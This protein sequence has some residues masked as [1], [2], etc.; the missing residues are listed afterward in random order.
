MKRPGEETLS[1][2]F[3]EKSCAS[4]GNGWQRNELMKFCEI[5]DIDCDDRDT[6]EQLCNK[7]KSALGLKKQKLYDIHYMD[8]DIM[9]QVNSE[10]DTDFTEWLDTILS[11]DTIKKNTY[12]T[13]YSK[14]KVYINKKF[15]ELIEKSKI[16]KSEQRA[17]VLESTQLNTVNA[18]FNYNESSTFAIHI[19]ECDSETCNVITKNVY[20][21]YS[22]KR[23]NIN[24]YPTSKLDADF[25]KGMNEDN[26]LPNI[27]FADFTNTFY[28]NV[29]TIKELMKCYKRNKTEKCVLAL[30]FS[31]RAEHHSMD[32]F[33]CEPHIKGKERN[34]DKKVA[35]CVV[36]E[37]WKIFAKN[38]Y[39]S[40][41]A[42]RDV[43]TRSIANKKSGRMQFYI[44]VLKKIDDT[45][46]KELY[47]SVLKMDLDDIAKQ[48]MMNINKSLK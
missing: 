38:G 5:T 47:K 29:K 31:M 23:T 28:S 25:I 17:L 2:L 21:M 24:F 43:Y 18:L 16:P 37:L 3:I 40:E 19:P 36:K 9:E 20:E 46:A 26:E 48:P 14:E 1:E 8:V 39:V 44:F 33:G 27:V 13:E 22:D 4:D 45:K 7:I 34:K 42:E 6:Q 11:Q 41:E 32:K 12:S 30:T 15:I 35:A 10:V